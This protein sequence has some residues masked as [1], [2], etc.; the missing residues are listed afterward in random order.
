MTCNFK[1]GD[2][3]VLLQDITIDEKTYLSG[4]RG[5]IDVESEDAI[6]ESVHGILALIHLQGR[7]QPVVLSEDQFAVLKE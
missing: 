4:T 5:M 2:M 3:V 7:K 6:H 1:D